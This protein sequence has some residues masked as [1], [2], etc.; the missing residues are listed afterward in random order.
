ME[1]F[2]FMLSKCNQKKADRTPLAA[3]MKLL[4]EPQA[5][6]W[7]PSLDLDPKYN[8]FPDNWMGYFRSKTSLK[9]G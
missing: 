6:H 8:N 1:K 9:T 3:G 4:T 2:S 7:L 5:P